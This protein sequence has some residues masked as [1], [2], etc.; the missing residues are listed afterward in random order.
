MAAVPS[1]LSLTPLR[2]IKKKL[3]VTLAPSNTSLTV[4]CSVT[5]TVDATINACFSVQ[6]VVILPPLQTAE[7]PDYKSKRYACNR[8]W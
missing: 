6:K 8:P 7:V 4:A 5:E 2:I 3:S 1:G